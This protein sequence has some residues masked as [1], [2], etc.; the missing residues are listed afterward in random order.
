MTSSGGFVKWTMFPFYVIFVGSQREK[1]NVPIFFPLIESFLSVSDRNPICIEFDLVCVI[2]MCV[3]ARARAFASTTRSM[4]ALYVSSFAIYL[5]IVRFSN[6]SGHQLCGDIFLYFFYR[7]SD[8]WKN[9]SASDWFRAR[10]KY[11][12]DDD[13][14]RGYKYMI[15]HDGNRARVERDVEPFERSI[16][17]YGRK[18]RILFHDR[19]YPRTRVETNE[20]VRAASDA[21]HVKKKYIE[22]FH[23]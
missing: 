14:D 5:T 22:I 13:I 15:R 21:L 8:E 10:R 1:K 12:N 2:I 17:I 4:C 11:R 18:E 23:W 7:L 9:F 3:R 20:I 19:S 16:R 6:K